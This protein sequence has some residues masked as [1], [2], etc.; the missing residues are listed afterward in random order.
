MYPSHVERCSCYLHT[1]YRQLPK[2]SLVC[3]AVGKLDIGCHVGPGRHQYKEVICEVCSSPYQAFLCLKCSSMKCEPK[4]PSPSTRPHQESPG[5]HYC[6]TPSS[7]SGLTSFQ[8]DS[9]RGAS[10]SSSISTQDPGSAKATGS[11]GIR[12]ARTKDTDRDAGKHQHALNEKQRRDEEKTNFETVQ[13][14]IEELQIVPLERCPKGFV[15]KND[16]L[17][18]A[19]KC[20][21][22]QDLENKRYKRELAELRAQMQGHN[23]SIAGCSD[24]PDSDRVRAMQ[25]DCQR[26]RTSQQIPKAPSGMDGLLQATTDLDV[27]PRL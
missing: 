9:D 2:L 25:T 26:R 24:D 17:K 15:P 20:I 5:V 3:T 23:I 16:I 11:T 19:I 14:T 8:S 21:R 4:T 22:I 12:N 10:H 13:K 7:S 1:L 27:K 6:T 18:A